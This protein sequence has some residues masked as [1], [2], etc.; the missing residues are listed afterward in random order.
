MSS[1]RCGEQMSQRMSLKFLLERSVESAL[2]LDSYQQWQLRTDAAKTSKSMFYKGAAVM[3]LSTFPDQAEAKPEAKPEA[4]FAQASLSRPAPFQVT[5][6]DG[7]QAK[8]APK[9]APKSTQAPAP[10]SAPEVA[11]CE[12]PK[13]EVTKPVPPVP[14]PPAPAPKAA[15]A[16]TQAQKTERRRAPDGKAYT[17]N[18]FLKFFGKKQGE[19][20][21]KNARKA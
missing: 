2:L 10:S 15:A 9:E 6:S 17:Y 4:K 21:W 12:G 14:Q 18:E 20:Q 5:T 1:E 3:Q 19:T 8:E 11:V 7:T 13:Q 16:S